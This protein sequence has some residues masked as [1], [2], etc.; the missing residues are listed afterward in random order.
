MALL[1]TLVIGAIVGWLA[2]VLMHA[3]YGILGSIVV[4]VLGSL[5]GHWLAGL[6]GIAAYGLIGRILVSVIG[7]MILIALLRALQGRRI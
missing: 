4:G 6:I 1:V 3:R 2:G 7:A 5:L